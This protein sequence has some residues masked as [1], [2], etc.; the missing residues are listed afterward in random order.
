MSFVIA[1]AVAGIGTAAVSIGGKVAQGVAAGNVDSQG[2]VNASTEL[3][4]AE[5]VQLGNKNK[6]NLE[7][8]KA[9]SD[10]LMD[11]ATVT[12][13]NSM[14]DI[15][16]FQEATAKSGFEGSEFAT[17]DATRV[18][19]A[20]YSQNANSVDKIVEESNLSKKGLS[21]SNIKESGDIE[22]RLQSNITAAT[23]QADTFWEGFSGSGD[24][25]VG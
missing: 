1:G 12:G 4:M 3:S 10:N 18:K 13:R 20:V 23:S 11:A 24:Y 19:D 17:S 5:R 2:A 6:I 22:K 25:K 15:F 7:Q 16:K 8:I 9:K 14:F 21:L